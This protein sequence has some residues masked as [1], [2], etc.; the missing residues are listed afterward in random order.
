ML[1]IPF[2]DRLLS[3][4]GASRHFAAVAGPHGVHAVEYRRERGEVVLVAGVRQ[5]AGGTDTEALAVAVADAVEALGG[6]GGT[7]SLAVS[8]YGTAH[9]VLSLPAAD[10]EILRPI[11][12]RELL[13]YYPELDDPV[14][15]FAVP[16]EAGGGAS[17]SREM[18]VGAAPRGVAVELSQ[19]L[20]E[21]GIVLHHLTVLPD[22][23]QTLYDTF[24]G[25]EAATVVVVVL[26]TGALI[27]CFHLG[28]LRL[29][30]EP[31]QDVHGRPVRDPT[32]VAEQVERANL[33]LRQ[34]FPNVRVDRVLLAA[35]SGEVDALRSALEEQLDSRVSSLADV[36]GGSLAA[37]GVA[38]SAD[39]VPRFQ[40][41]PAA[42]RPRT[43]S[44]RVTRRV[45]VAAGA[46][47]VLA[48]LWWAGAGLRVARA[49]AARAE[50]VE[51]EV[52]SVLPEVNRT[53]EILNA[54]RA[55]HLRL[56]FLDETAAS[57][58]EARRIL[59]GVAAES[60][61]EVRLESLVIQRVEAG[62][63]VSLAGRSEGGSSAVA[64]RAIDGLYRGMQE[65]LPVVQAE[66][67]GWK[68]WAGRATR[69]LPLGLTCRLL[70]NGRRT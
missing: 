24:D 65:R 64:V 48:A 22:V 12:R 68:R 30:I 29:F 50:A 43:H 19:R 4:G 59:A 55:H 16:A 31:P 62:W 3:P 52:S 28:A 14:I 69:P 9:H 21:R 60:R 25:S 10:E 42:V 63:S 15:D 54:R 67:G 26:E 1:R 33:F 53:S 5:S 2:L 57:R 17:T 51:T 7:L 56:V 27:G 36:P 45:S 47:I 66:F 61:P 13:R 34:Q 40:L 41:L 20:G 37:L 23:L 38:L 39:R 44:E 11:V 8:G 49:E 58:V 35:P 6:G 18:L 46:L 70:S 32:A